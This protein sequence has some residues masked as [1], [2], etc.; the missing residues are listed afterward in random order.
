ML[1][2]DERGGTVS[3][4]GEKMAGQASGGRE[5]RARGIGQGQRRREEP[6]TRTPNFKK[7]TP[8][9]INGWEVKLIIIA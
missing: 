1:H 4:E 8:F 7:V 9:L 6:L 3:T 5:E 2:S